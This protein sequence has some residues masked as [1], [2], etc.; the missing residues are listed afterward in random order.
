MPGRFDNHTAFITGASSGIGRALALEFAKAGARVALAARRESVLHEVQA[1]IEATGGKAIS[2]PCD[3]TDRRSLDAAVA[4]AVETFGGIDVAVANA[5]FGVTGRFA[6][7]NTEDFRRQFETNV[8][9]VI[10]TVYAVLPHLE[11]SRGRLGIVS[12]LLGHIGLPASSA[13]CASKFALCGLAET[14]LYELAATGVSVTSICPGIVESNIRRVD[15]QGVLH[16]DAIEQAPRF[17]TYPT[18]KAA[19]QIVRALYRRKPE[20]LIT[21]HAKLLLWAHR[22]FARPF[23]RLALLAI[24]GRIGAI[25]RRKRARIRPGS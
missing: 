15:N 21:G 14:L 22:H 18:D 7:L 10:D 3:V 12:S 13:Y 9:G 4:R 2:V 23:R 16:P 11:A 20:V 25:E 24:K 17:L 19:R 5:G 6:K 1:H 8:F